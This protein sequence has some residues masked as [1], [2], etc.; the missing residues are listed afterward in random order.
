MPSPTPVSVSAGRR[1]AP[2]GVDLLGKWDPLTMGHAPDG[3]ERCGMERRCYD[4][5]GDGLPVVLADGVA[6]GTWSMTANGK[7][8]ELGLELFEAPGARLRTAIER[9]AEEVAAL[10]A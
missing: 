4:F 6:L 5:R 7:R 9:R 3:R 10:L 1:P 8:L 2:R